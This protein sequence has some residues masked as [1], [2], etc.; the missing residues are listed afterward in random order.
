MSNSFPSFGSSLGVSDLTGIKYKDY[1]KL[2]IDYGGSGRKKRGSG[3]FEA[4]TKSLERK[5]DKDDTFNR[6]KAL[7]LAQDF[8]RGSTKISDDATLVE[9]YTDP[10]FSYEIPGRRGFGDIIGAGVG[11]VAGSFIPGMT[12]MMGANLGRNIGGRF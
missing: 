9:G 3:I 12:P 4:F 8:K 11:A 5:E 2:D 6:A 7:S 10:G 1:P